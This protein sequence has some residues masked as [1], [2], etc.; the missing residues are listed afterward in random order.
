MITLLFF[1][2]ERK[3]RSHQLCPSKEVKCQTLGLLVTCQVF[4]NS[5]PTYLS[6][7]LEKLQRR[8]LRIIY[9]DISYAAALKKSNLVT[10]YIR[11]QELTKRSFTGIGIDIQIFR[12]AIINFITCY[13]RATAVPDL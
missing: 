2:A 1:V 11:R 9:P 8:A 6:D 4:P 5:L 12:I 3:R 7:E 10:L 13:P